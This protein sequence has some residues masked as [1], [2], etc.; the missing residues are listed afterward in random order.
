M[1][2]RIK[3]AISNCYLLRGKRPVLIDTGAPGDLKRIL[4]GLKGAG[5]APRDL[6]LILLTHGHSDHAGCAA[7]LRRR[8]GAQIALHAG[9]LPLVQAGRN[10]VIAV[11]DWIGRVI[12]P[13][14]D[15]EFEAFEPDLVFKEG[16]A[17]EPY[18]LRGR[19]LPTPGHTAGSISVVLANGEALIGDTLRGSLVWP[20]RAREHYFCNDPEL[21]HRS[22]VRLA[23]EGL[24][25]CHPG[26]FGS[27]PGTE[28]GRFLSTS[29]GEVMEL[30]GEAV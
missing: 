18:G 3:G 1:L 17:L 30:S 11:Q 24:L 8:T 22:L 23:R 9:D 27:F 7:E 12:R 10:G 14:V 4:A 28:L 26:V 21:N 15:E 29:G 25:R 13:L 20:N 19:V 2:I 5:V 6:A 16:I